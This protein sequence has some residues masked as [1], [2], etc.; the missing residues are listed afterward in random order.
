MTTKHRQHFALAVYPTCHGFSFVLFEGPDA[1][2]DWGIKEVREK[3]KNEKT[4]D[5]I[6]AILERY[7]PE[8]L[9]IE[10]TGHGSRRTTRIR[11]L[12][13]MLAHLAETES[14]EV[15]RYTRADIR[16]CFASVGAKTKYEIAKAIAKEIPA[17]MHRLPPVR[18]I[19]MSEDSR[20]SLF[21]AAALGITHYAADENAKGKKETG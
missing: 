19:W 3:Q 9:V 11:R 13:K 18:K 15:V 14:V 6:Q 10:D 12:Y 7:R 4:L 5:G 16:A 20:Q 17:F 21:D 2:F 8:V 1:P